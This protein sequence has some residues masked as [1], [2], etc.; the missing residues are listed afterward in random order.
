VSFRWDARVHEV[1]PRD[2]KRCLPEPLFWIFRVHRCT[3]IR[4]LLDVDDMA[5]KLVL[6][7]RISMIVSQQVALIGT[8]LVDSQFLKI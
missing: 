8:I 4:R 3:R 5:H 1:E 6:L 7:H 2:V